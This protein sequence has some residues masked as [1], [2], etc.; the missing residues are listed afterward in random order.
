MA[1]LRHS[2]AMEL[3]GCL[4][5]WVGAAL[6]L[7]HPAVPT[8]AAGGVASVLHQWDAARAAAWAAGDASALRQLYT[9][10]SPAG[11]AD[12]RLLRRYA[13]RGL[14]VRGLETQV[15]SIRVLERAPRRVAVRLVDRIVGGVAVGD[16][17]CLALPRDRADTRTVTLRL[18]RGRWLVADVR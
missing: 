9:R 8:T 10:G 3:S 16:G 17:R 15:F 18:V 6:S 5:W 4:V 11:R 13:E 7:V 2:G 1:G 12:V 14:R